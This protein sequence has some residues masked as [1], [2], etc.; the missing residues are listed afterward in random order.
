MSSVGRSRENVAR[1]SPITSLYLSKTISSIFKRKPLSA[2][3]DLYAVNDEHIIEHDR[4]EGFQ[5]PLVPH[6]A[7]FYLRYLHARN[8]IPFGRPNKL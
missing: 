6:W 8:P 1:S 4:A 5:I 2:L 3:D 7:D